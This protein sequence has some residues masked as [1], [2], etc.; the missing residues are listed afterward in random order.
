MNTPMLDRRAAIEALGEDMLTANRETFNRWLARGDGLAIYE[1]Q[2]LSSGSFGDRKIA[3]FGSPA[4]QLEDATPPA[5]LPDIG[6]SI[7]WRYCLVG[8]YKGDP[9]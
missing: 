4:A 7:N 1:N 6:A 8:A 9:L 2:D 5:K 3:S